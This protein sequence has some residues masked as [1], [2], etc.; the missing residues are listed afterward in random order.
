MENR[1]LYKAI[2]NTISTMYNGDQL[3]L[4]VKADII[5]LLY[6]KSQ[7]HLKSNV[8]SYNIMCMKYVL[9]LRQISD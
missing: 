3:I 9:G 8:I 6:Y 1:N 4:E 2:E 5:I 7:E